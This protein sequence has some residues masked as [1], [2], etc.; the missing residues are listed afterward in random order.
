MLVT[1]ELPGTEGATGVGG[2]EALSLS[3]CPFPLASL[4]SSP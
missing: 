3:T 1:A 4:L 2:Q